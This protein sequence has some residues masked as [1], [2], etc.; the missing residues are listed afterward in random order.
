MWHLRRVHME[1]VGHPDARFDPL[2]VELTDAAGEPTSSVLWLENMGGKT[3]WLSLVFSTLRPSLTEFL[4]RPDKQ[5]G[6]YVL[7][8]DTAHVILE[9][10]QVAGVRTLTGSGTRLMLGQV[11]Q[12][13]QHRQEKARESAQLNRQLWGILVPPSGGPLTF[14]AAVEL[15][16]TDGAQRRPLADFTTQLADRM[17]G[18]AFRP[19]SNQTRWAEW[20]RHHGLDPDVF[21]DQL[22]MSA[23]EGSISER[24]HFETGDHLVQWAM[25]YI[26]PPEVPDGIAAVVDQVKD[27]LAQR[28]SLLAQQ[29]FCSTVES[30]L[31]YAATQQR[32]LDEQRA[33]ATVV[34]D[35]SLQVADQFR[36]AQIAADQAVDHH[37]NEA[38][39]FEQ[40]ARDAQSLRNQRQQQWRQA[41]LVAARLHHLESSASHQE[42]LAQLRASQLRV[43]AWELTT[44][45]RRLG[46]IETRLGQINALLAEVDDQARPLREAVAV[47]EHRLAAKLGHLLKIEQA[48]LDEAGERLK[49]ERIKA[50]QAG[51]SFKTAQA[52]Y[53]GATSD[54][55]TAEANLGQLDAEVAE[56]IRE[57]LLDRGQLLDDA[58]DTRG[59]E[60]QRLLAEVERLTGVA[61]TAEAEV[62]A[63]RDVVAQARRA[64]AACRAAFERAAARSA[65][66]TSGAERLLDLPHVAAAFDAAHPDLWHDGPTAAD[67]LRRE[68]E[69]AATE[70]VAIELR[71]ATDQRAVDWLDR[72]GLLPP[73]QDVEAAL[74]ALA[75]RGIRSAFSAW[76]V[77][78][79]QIP[80]DQ[81]AEVISLHPEIVTG[82]VLTD[83]SELDAAIE[84]LSDFSPMAPTVLSTGLPV[85]NDGRR[86]GV[87]V[88]PG[89]AALHDEDAAIGEGER[90]QTQLDVASTERETVIEQE[91]DAR[92]AR[93]QLLSFLNANPLDAVARL[94]SEE[95]D[96]RTEHHQAEAGLRDAESACDEADAL[97]RSALAAVQPA[98]DAHADAARAESAVQKLARNQAR[99]PQEER[100][101]SQAREHRDEAERQMQAADTARATAT[102]QIEAAQ[103]LIGEVRI[104]IS[105]IESSLTHHRL[106]PADQAAPDAP[107]DTLERALEDA[108]QELIAAAPP[109]QVVKER[110]DLMKESAELSP[111]LRRRDEEVVDQARS[112]LAGPEGAN[113]QARD[114]A[115]R[116]AKKRL[117]LTQGREALA[118]DALDKAEADLTDKEGIPQSRRSALDEEPR[119]A[120]EARALAD[121]LAA[122]ASS[123]LAQRDEAAERQA[124]HAG[125]ADQAEQTAQAFRREADD[126]I[127]LLRR[128]ASLM[129]RPA[130]VLEERRHAAAW[131]GTAAQA[132]RERRERETLLDDAAEYMRIATEERNHALD[133]VRH[134][135]NE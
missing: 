69:A 96:R 9:F 118:R 77:L 108:R 92:D 48:T 116:E 124:H 82:I 128:H 61:T 11:L 134:L 126:L 76:E 60:V 32:Q 115:T 94:R 86:E 45:L 103:A 113:V 40:V 34:W 18:D 10:A 22:K 111:L 52:T 117:S 20:L 17:Q 5:L 30:K 110:D 75:K 131:P 24:F 88:L 26:I 56:A 104:R 46:A 99:R 68:A 31:A 6:D 28:P 93:A 59:T 130:D 71:T 65:A 54:A 25:P 41:Q 35:S 89:P 83:P 23:D 101:A 107:V 67:R 43:E 119:T 80:A 62:D 84:A 70:R 51:R 15:V 129:R 66:V 85:H 74:A 42:A 81:H 12:W 125:Q 39:R 53:A 109:D 3:S 72:T 37:R 58:V 73:S 19:D 95:S 112:L 105:Q 132:E 106:V 2:T 87:V 7:G 97:A 121:R 64:E 38:T 78:R 49:Q 63:A 1:S 98:R 100:A 133:D 122:E 36:A 21:A 120:D 29:R 123:A 13:R 57:G 8:T 44:A 47:A 27:T 127:G 33:E 50:K 79:T 135:A 16:R 90:R 102:E 114:I 55:A 91:V 14:E 4:G